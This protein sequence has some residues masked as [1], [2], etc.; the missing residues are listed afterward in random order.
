MPLEG[1]FPA[2]KN[3]LGYI[4]IFLKERI[5]M[6]VHNLPDGYKEIGRNDFSKDTKLMIR[7]RVINLAAITA[8]VM[9]GR[10]FVSFSLR[11]GD[12]SLAV[13]ILLLV[14]SIIAYIYA[15][16]WVHGICYRIFSGKKANLGI[17]K[18]L[19]PFAGSDAYF[20]KSQY[21][22]ICLTPGVVFGVLL[23]L[24]SIFLP[25]EWFWHIYILQIVNLSGMVGD[26]H[27][28]LLVRKF[29]ADM[30]VQDIGASAIYYSRMSE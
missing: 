14:L 11:I 28:T 26:I 1:L 30:L 7:M 2:I 16:E 21:R 5:I 13:S 10:Y 12:L 15:H 20:N 3:D 18:G 25:I 27:L 6:G 24:L 23:L 19:I 8:L 9:V 22:V 17:A 29:P 4:K